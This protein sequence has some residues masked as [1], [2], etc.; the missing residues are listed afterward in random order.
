MPR[1]ST[2][3]YDKKEIGEFSV[4]YSE[5]NEPGKFDIGRG[6][7]RQDEQRIS[8]STRQNVSSDRRTWAGNDIKWIDIQTLLG[9]KTYR[10]LLVQNV[11]TTSYVFKE[12]PFSHLV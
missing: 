1:K 10:E 4:N 2:P 8:S 11:L 12:T 6:Y 5:E 7:W 9:T 3:K